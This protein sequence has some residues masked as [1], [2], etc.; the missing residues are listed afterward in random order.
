MHAPSC[1]MS[2][3][4][5]WREPTWSFIRASYTAT[6]CFLS[7]VRVTIGFSMPSAHGVGQ[8]AAIE[9]TAARTV[10]RLHR[11][12]M[13]RTR[14]FDVLGWVQAVQPPPRPSEPS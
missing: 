8:R 2:S 3:T 10:S 1:M 12:V 9:T 4:T 11:C 7:V 5:A 6:K 13:V 14:R